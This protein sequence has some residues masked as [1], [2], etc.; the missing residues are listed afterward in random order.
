M[1]GN[2]VC[3]NNIDTGFAIVILFC[4]C[5]SIS[6]AVHYSSTV[7]IASGIFALPFFKSC[8]HPPSHSTVAI[9]TMYLV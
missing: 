1:D 5:Y 2:T 6:S 8:Y 9:K 7:H 4:L 3:R